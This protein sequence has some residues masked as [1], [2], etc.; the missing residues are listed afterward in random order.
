MTNYQD[1]DP[2][3]IKEGLLLTEDQVHYMAVCINGS[4]RLLSSLGES[5]SRDSAA[6]PQN[7]SLKRTEKFIEKLSSDLKYCVT[8]LRKRHDL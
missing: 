7:E 1:I 2:T 6:D 3:E 8:I 4:V 5:V